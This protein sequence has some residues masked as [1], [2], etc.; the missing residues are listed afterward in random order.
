MLTVRKKCRVRVRA[1]V[2]VSLMQLCFGVRLYVRVRPAGTFELISHLSC[3]SPSLDNTI[4][5]SSTVFLL[6]S[7]CAG[8]GESCWHVCPPVWINAGIHG[9]LFATTTARFPS[10]LLRTKLL[11]Q[12]SFDIDE[13]HLFGFIIFFFLQLEQV[14]FLHALLAYHMFFYFKIIFA[15]AAGVSAPLHSIDLLM[16]AA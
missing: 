10:L 15:S 1:L 8:G 16:K 9:C 14:C 11:R 4:K 3:R 2:P 6:Y 5:A 13:H 7:L 12:A